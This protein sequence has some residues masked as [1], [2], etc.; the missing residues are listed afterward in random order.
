MS[1]YPRN[2]NHTKPLLFIHIPKSAGTS[3]KLWY[4]KVYSKFEKVTHGGLSHPVLES[5]SQQMESFTIVRNPYDLVYSWYRYKK[6]MLSETRH[7]DPKELATWHKGFE[8]W[9]ERYFT[10]VNL[11]KYGDSYNK[12]SPSFSQSSYL[13]DSAGNFKIDH[14]LQLENIQQDWDKIKSLTSTQFDLDQRNRSKVTGNYKG[15]YN[16]NT[17]R[18]VEQAYSEDLERFKYVF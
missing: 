14:V 8:Y 18:I 4:K 10:K 1:Y 17:R 11:T 9:L 15:A 7:R 12:I 3:V 16:A 2:L 13:K 5:V 6:Q